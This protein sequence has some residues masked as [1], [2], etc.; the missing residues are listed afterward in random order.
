MIG[1]IFIL[2]VVVI[3]FSIVSTWDLPERKRKVSIED[4][5]ESQLR[6]DRVLKENEMLMKKMLD[7]LREKDLK[8]DRK[9]RINS[10][11]LKDKDAL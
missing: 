11:N 5:F 1:F 2:I 7:K 3:L 6:L 8:K 4:V 10:L 9:T